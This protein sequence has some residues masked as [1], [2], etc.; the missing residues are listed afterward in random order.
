MQK[1][2]LDNNGF[3]FFQ[4]FELF[5]GFI[6][7]PKL[8][9]AISF[10]TMYLMYVL[11]HRDSLG[12]SNNEMLLVNFLVYCLP[13]IAFLVFKYGNL[14][15]KSTRWVLLI[16]IISIFTLGIVLSGWFYGCGAFCVLLSLLITLSGELK[17]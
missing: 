10:V 8:L 16:M 13:I 14:S 3:G 17:N 1:K 11:I 9:T 5:Q 15:K 2:A 4:L 7:K 12:N 6:K